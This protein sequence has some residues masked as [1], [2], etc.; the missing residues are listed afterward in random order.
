MK[1]KR[2][3]KEKQ[4]KGR[5]LENLHYEIFFKNQM[6]SKKENTELERKTSVKHNSKFKKYIFKN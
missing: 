4:K 2:R 3:K 6:V 5:H 1:K